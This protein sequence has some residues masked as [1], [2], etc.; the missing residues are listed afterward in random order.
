MTRTDQNHSQGE[1]LWEIVR[2]HITVSGYVTVTSIGWPHVKTI[3]RDDGGTLTSRNRQT[4]SRTCCQHMNTQTGSQKCSHVCRYTHTNTHIYSL[5][6]FTLHLTLFFSSF[7]QSR[8]PLSSTHMHRTV[9]RYDVQAINMPPM[10]KTQGQMQKQGKFLNA[11]VRH[12]W[13]LNTADLRYSN[14]ASFKTSH[15]SHTCLS[16]QHKNKSAGVSYPVLLTRLPRI[17]WRQCFVSS[18]TTPNYNA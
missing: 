14:T 7:K 4:K 16:Y 13:P 18:A 17:V 8:K 1:Y 6:S 12:T 2:P 3:N 15:L 11:Y 10:S 5:C 9:Q